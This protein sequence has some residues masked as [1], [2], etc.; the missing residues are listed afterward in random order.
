MS[1]VANNKE[2]WKKIKR[3]GHFR[4]QKNSFIK[5]ALFTAGKS[6]GS[7]Q[8]ESQAKGLPILTMAESINGIQTSQPEVENYVPVSEQECEINCS[9][10]DAKNGMYEL[11][12]DLKTWALE[13]KVKHTA[14]NS[15]LQT[16]KRHVPD[17]VLPVDART[18]VETPRKVLIVQDDAMGGKYWHYG[19]KTA[20]LNVLAHISNQ[21]V[22]R[23][24]LN[25]NIDGVPIS[26]STTTSFWPILVKIH[27]IS[28]ISAQ[29]VGI[30]EG[31]CKVH[32]TN[33]TLKSSILFY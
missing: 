23:I 29:V 6:T 17:N 1:K 12:D 19:L 3:N 5:N 31:K 10:L 20:L 32:N 14:V 11:R 22:D 13:H 21:T 27:E 8:L 18:L 30:F 25:I 26:K 33:L 24:S 4:K 16:L 7:T 15:L 9:G 2:I 28:Q